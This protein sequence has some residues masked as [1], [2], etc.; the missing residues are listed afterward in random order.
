MAR[1]R[2]EPVPSQYEHMFVNKS[3]EEGWV[4][5]AA[6]SITYR[7]KPA[8]I[9][10]FID[11]TENKRAEERMQAALAEKVVL[12]K[13]VHHRVKNNL[14]IVSSL[15]ELQSDS[16][17]GEASRRYIRESQDRIRSIA[18]VHEQLYKS[19]D[20]SVIDFCQLCGRVGLV[21]L[22]LLGDRPGQNPRRRGGSGYRAWHR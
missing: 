3:G 8:G 18:L 14:Q 7:G 12:L 21:S 11:I 5:V 10:T 19:E 13:E 16:I 9:A 15:L 22:P 1:Q 20:L 6:G 17:E 4:M 2:G